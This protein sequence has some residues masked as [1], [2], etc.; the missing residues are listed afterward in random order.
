LIESVRQY[1]NPSYALTVAKS[2]TYSGMAKGTS[3]TVHG[4]PDEGSTFTGWSNGTGSALS[5]TGNEI[6]SF[7]TTADSSIIDSLT[8]IASAGQ[9]ANTYG[10]KGDDDAYCI[11][12]TSDGG[13]IGGRCDLFLWCRLL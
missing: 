12:Q 5:Y 11:Q 2:G 9:W 8:G 13:L 4:T 10:G 3:I 7:T 6:C 1:Y